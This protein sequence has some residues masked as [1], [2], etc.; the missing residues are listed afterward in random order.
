M[1]CRVCK[2]TGEMLLVWFSCRQ[3]FDKTL[4]SCNS[5]TS[6]HHHRLPRIIVISCDMLYHDLVLYIED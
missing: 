6:S 3:L 4:C 1:S 5:S 2:A